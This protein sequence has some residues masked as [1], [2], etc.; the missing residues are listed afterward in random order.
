MKFVPIETERLIIRELI[1]EDAEGMFEMDS[2]PEV[3][4]YLGNEPVH[5]LQQIKDVIQMIRRQYIENGI[6]RWAMLDKQSGEFIGWTG[7]KLIKEPT[8]S[9]VEYYDLGYRMKRKFWGMGYATESAKASVRYCFEHHLA[10]SLYAMSDVENSASRHVLEKCGL[11]YV[12]TFDLDGTPHVWMQLSR[13]D[14]EKEVNH[15]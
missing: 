11:R 15:I 8:N 4:R 3:H 9:H 10:E 6:G 2:D 1:P 14:W 7:L 5:E 13:V 12:E